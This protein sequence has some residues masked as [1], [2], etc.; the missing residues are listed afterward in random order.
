M[1]SSSQT[2]MLFVTNTTDKTLSWSQLSVVYKFTCPG[3][4]GSYIG[5][6]ERT[7]HEKMEEHAYPYIKSNKQSLIY[8]HLSTCS[9]PPIIV[10]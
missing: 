3:C 4:S 9:P 5:K 1:L 8:E 10:T 7:L 2:I 6:M